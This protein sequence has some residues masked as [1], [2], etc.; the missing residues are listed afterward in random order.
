[1]QIAKDI[2]DLIGNTPLVWLNKINAGNPAR[3]AA[4]LEYFN[5]AGSVKDR[6]GLALIH[7]AEEKGQIHQDT[8]ILEPTSGNTGI[9]IAFIAA[10]RGYHCA[11]VMPESVSSERKRILQAFGAEI[12]LTSAEKGMKGAIQKA[13]QMA[14]EDPRYFIPNQ[15]EN[16]ANPDIHRKTTAE[17]I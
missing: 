10:A 13:Q 12:I 1:M 11:L 16:P 7:S 14:E 5:P 17:E 3:I 8:I 2:T 6:L 9:G 15:F 4:K